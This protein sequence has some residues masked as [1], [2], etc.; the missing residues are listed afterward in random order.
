MKTKEFFIHFFW[1]FVVLFLVF[2]EVGSV[3]RV[4]LGCYPSF[5]FVFL[6]FFSQKIQKKSFYFLIVLL[7]GSIFDMF[8]PYFLFTP[9]LFLFSWIFIKLRK[10]IFEIRLGLFLI[11]VF[12]SSFL[13]EFFLSLL[14]QIE[15]VLG[16]F[17]Y[18]LNALL[19][20]KQM[21]FNCLFATFLYF[22]FSKLPTKFFYEESSIKM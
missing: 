3:R 12:L 4:F 2:L 18:Q 15:N 10:Y 13:F 6:V 20:L 16:G 5:I 11:L 21:F 7:I 22:I 14:G 8:A 17:G 19:F 1:I 9:I